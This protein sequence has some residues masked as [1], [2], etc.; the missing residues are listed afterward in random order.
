MV[1]SCPPTAAGSLATDLIIEWK[2]TPPFGGVSFQKGSKMFDINEKAVIITGCSS[3]VGEATAKLFAKQGAKLIICARRTDMLND[4]ASQI[5]SA[6]GEVMA[7]T[8]DISKAEDAQA[9][10]DSC[11]EKY[12]RIDILINNAGVQTQNDITFLDRDTD[13][14]WDYVMSNNAR[15]VFN[16]LRAALKKMVETGGVIVNVASA[17][18]VNGGGD[19]V[20]AASKG[21]VIAMTKHV[22][23]AYA[24]KKIRC[25]AICPGSILT[26]MTLPNLKG[27]GLDFE[28]IG[29]M[30]KHT[31]PSLGAATAEDIAE[32]ILYFASDSSKNTT[33]QIVVEDF[34]SSL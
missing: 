12:G 26:P 18:G 3:G 14:V 4:V 30:N 7:L 19:G 27:I 1:L 31:D 24:A 23:L 5:K 32:N 21:A 2:G 17:A 33:G 6:G 25:N 29:E 22:A 10:V 11:M 28:L 15:G 9:V 20:Y 8:A 16:M 34:G 13:E